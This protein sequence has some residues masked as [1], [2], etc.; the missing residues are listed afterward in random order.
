MTDRNVE[1]S[2]ELTRGL[3]SK[4]PAAKFEFQSKELANKSDKPETTKTGV[5]TKVP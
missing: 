3:D 4:L 2:L 5:K 1:A